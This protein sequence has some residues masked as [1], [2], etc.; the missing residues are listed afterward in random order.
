[1][2]ET[3]ALEA[4]GH[5]DEIYRRRPPTEVS[6]YQ[7]EPTVSLALLDALGV[8]PEEPIIDVGGGASVLVDRLLDR[9]FGD[10]SVLDVSAA[11]L[12]HA[13]HRLGERAPHVHWLRDDVL[14]WRPERRYEIWHDRA[15][16]HF[17]VEEDQRTAYLAALRAA[18]TPEARVV[19]G[20]FAGDGPQRCSGL[21]VRRYE[22]G[23][24]ASVFGAEFELVEHRRDEHHTP[25]GTE[26][27]FTWVGMVRRPR[28]R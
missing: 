10:V 15:V 26:Q 28:V 25:G 17:L 16:F 13:R 11:A 21:P 1:M 4:A 14:A 2:M 8:T 20:T 3:G 12:A 6:W 7:D 5:W 24:L 27:P 22:P 23:D 19:I 9:G 18:L